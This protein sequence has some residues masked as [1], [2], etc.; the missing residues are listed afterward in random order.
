M[1]GLDDL[2][3]AHIDYAEEERRNDDRYEDNVGPFM[4]SFREGQV[5]R[6]VSRYTS[7]KYSLTL[8]SFL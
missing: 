8:S 7:L 5:T 3:Q 6:F 4:V 2:C 1:N